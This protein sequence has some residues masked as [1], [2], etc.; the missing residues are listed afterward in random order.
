VEYAQLA[1]EHGS[2]MPIRWTSRIPDPLVLELTV[3]ARYAGY[4]ERQLAEIGRA[5]AQE[6]TA[7]PERLDY[8]AVAACRTKYARSSRKTRPATVGQASRVPGVTPAAI[9]LL[10][11]HLKRTARPE[12]C[13][14]AAG[15]VPRDGN[16]V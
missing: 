14:A 7:L 15:V 13:A 9:S 6:E 8:A 3:R 11:V 12:A 2:S 1:A 4:I 5:R 10:L 16:S